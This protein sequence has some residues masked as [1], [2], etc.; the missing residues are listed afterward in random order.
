MQDYSHRSME[1]HT[2]ELTLV[3][4]RLGWSGRIRLGESVRLG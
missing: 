1:S 4:I 3:S 2:T